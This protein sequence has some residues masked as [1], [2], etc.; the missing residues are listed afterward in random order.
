MVAMIF[1][2][3]KNTKAVETVKTWRGK[4]W[5]LGGG[6][7]WEK[8][9]NITSN[10]LLHQMGCNITVLQMFLGQRPRDLKKYNNH[11]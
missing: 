3:Y 4:F 11:L 6:F 7:W 2:E 10:G 8:W 9:G 1:T 5:C